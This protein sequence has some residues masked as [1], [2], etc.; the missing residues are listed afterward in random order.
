M[1]PHLCLEEPRALNAEQCDVTDVNAVR[2]VGL[3]LAV[4]DK[5]AVRD[6]DG[7]LRQ[8]SGEDAVL[9]VDE[10][11]MLDRQVS[12]LC[13]NAGAVTIGNARA[14]KRDIASGDGAAD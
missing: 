6:F 4:V 10:A 13:P 11:A 14:C 8:V 12:S 5:L 1:M 9:V 2:A 3:T 7:T